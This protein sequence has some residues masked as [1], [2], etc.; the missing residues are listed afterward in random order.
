MA[1]VPTGVA[2]L[3]ERAR[4]LA[5]PAEDE[6]AAER[7]LT[8]V[9]FFLGESACAIELA[10]VD[11]AVPRL[12]EVE[13]LAGAPNAVRGI[14]FIDNLPRLVV[15]LQAVTSAH[16]RSLQEIA[17]APALVMRWD[18]TVLAVSVGGPLELMEGRLAAR[19][20]PSD[21]P[22]LGSIELSAQLTTG[23]MVISDG[24]LQRWAAAI[25]AGT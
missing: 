20:R 13:P 24:W 7:E 6:E 15:D 9:G 22:G 12:G 25:A 8:V 21:A 23:V 1:I 10:R 11:K 17:A 4:L 5:H 14:A 19:A 16:P 2:V 18:A 3:E